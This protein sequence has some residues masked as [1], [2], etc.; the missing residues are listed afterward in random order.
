MG[1]VVVPLLMLSAGGALVWSGITDPEGGTFAGLSTLLAGGT[2]TK[3]PADP[4][5][6][7]GIAYTLAA[8]G[9]TRGGGRTATP[10]GAAGTP[11]PTTTPTPAPPATGGKSIY[12]LGAVQ[13]WVARAANEMGPMFGITSVGGY[14]ASAVDPNGHPAGR[15]LDFMVSDERG[16]ALAAYAL[17]NRRRL[18]VTYVIW[19]QRINSGTGWRQMEDRGSPTQNHMDH[20]H[21][22]FAATDPRNGS[23]ST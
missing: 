1:N 13:P 15:A 2:P 11:G 17:A 16:T 4:A 18:G 9:G 7:N 8:A 10:T 14:R 3:R 20:V 6:A 22:N 19:R 12:S 5:A 23:S 21:V